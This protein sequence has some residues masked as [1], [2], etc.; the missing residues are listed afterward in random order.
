MAAAR[1]SVVLVPAQDRIACLDVLAAEVTARGWAASVVAP[2]HRAPRLFVQHPSDTVMSGTILAAP[3]DATSE[4]WYWFGWAE[5]I[6][7]AGSPTQAADAIAGTLGRG[8][9]ATGECG[10]ATAPGEPAPAPSSRRGQR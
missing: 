4:W 7:P 2:P 6:A 8:A 1:P 10:T 5:R 3:D 9:G